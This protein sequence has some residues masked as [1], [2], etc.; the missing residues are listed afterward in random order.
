MKDMS[1]PVYLDYAACT[2]VDPH[3]VEAMM[4]WMVDRPG[5]HYARNHI[6]GQAVAGRI[7]Q[8]RAQIARRIGAT[9]QEIVF[10]ASATEANNLAILGLAAH[11][12]K[13]GKTHIVTHEIEHKS[14]LGPVN[15]LAKKGFRVT[16]IPAGPEGYITAEDIEEALTPQTGLVSIQAVNNELGTVQPIT[17]IAAL[18]LGRDIFFHTDAAQALGKVNFSIAGANIMLASLSAQKCY[19]PRGIAALYVRKDIEEHMEPLLQGGSGEERLRPGSLPVAL[20][21]GFGAAA[22]L[23]VY[24]EAETI[25]LE[26]MR[27]IFLN[28]IGAEIPGASIL[29]PQT[30]EKRVAGII[31]LCIPRISAATFAESLPQL[32]FGIRPHSHVIRAIT[33]GGAAASETIRLSF[34]RFTNQEALNDATGRIIDMI[35]RGKNA[36]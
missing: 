25:R 34:G 18:L 8:A 24:K 4:E 11:L 29:G 27:E 16:V 2:P 14:I 17:R 30:Q 12:E 33:K 13:T 6:Y 35:K 21:A 15:F 19:G 1:E 32:A 20:C 7:E 26:A 22:D 5:S 28:R 10:T 3:V 23:A 31:S 36:K 9:P